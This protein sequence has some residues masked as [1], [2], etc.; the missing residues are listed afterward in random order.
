MRIAKGCWSW[1]ALPLFGSVLFFILC[2]FSLWLL[3]G[4]IPG[5]TP[6]ITGDYT[7]QDFFLQDFWGF[8]LVGAFMLFC[9]VIFLWKVKEVPTGDK[10]FHVGDHPIKI[11][12]YTQNFIPYSEGT[13]VHLLHSGWRDTPESEEAR[14]FFD[15]AWAVSLSELQK[16][17]GG[18][19]SAKCCE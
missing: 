19:D 5:T 7:T 9:L 18:S 8:M 6:K 4:F 2:W 11:D 3:V 17:V 16:Y 12:V 13:E 15:K 1:L 14:Q 10:F